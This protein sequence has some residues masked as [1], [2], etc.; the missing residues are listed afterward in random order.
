VIKK[1][2]VLIIEDNEDDA[3]LIVNS[4]KEADYDPEFLI[5]DTIQELIKSLQTR[6]WDC[7]LSD[8][9][10]PT[11]NGLQSLIEFQKFNLTI[12]FIIV[13]G[14]IGEEL[15]VKVMKAGA[16]DFVN[17]NNLKFL[18]PIIEDRL[19]IA[20][21]R[22]QQIRDQEALVFSEKQLRESN[23]SKD[24]FFSIISH[25]LRSPINGI[26]GIS[27]IF[28]DEI[29]DLSKEEIIK[30]VDIIHQNCKYINDHL[31]N[32]LEWSRIQTGS[33]KNE[34]TMLNLAENVNKIVLLLNLN[35]VNKKIKL[36]VSLNDNYKV[37]ADQNCLQSILQNLISNSI[38]YTRENG[39]INICSAL[40]DGF[41][42]ISIS[43]NGVGMDENQMGKLFKIDNTYS[44]PGTNEERGTGL[45]LLL[46]KE[47]IELNGGKISI[48]SKY[49]EGTNISFTLPH[50]DS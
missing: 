33:M 22:R 29:N 27:Q 48:R 46:C 25:D 41:I 13:S 10:L 3:V 49:G 36:N 9:S 17:K 28:L 20:E 32:L 35:A 50:I 47:L 34:P 4:L 1:I 43:D 12:P 37:Y 42:E 23:A 38:K 30:Y 18:V 11:F 2:R 6:T 44:T 7:V 16:S 5:V 40:K 45:G 26:L 8:Y 21:N 39:E 19:L 15:A 31:S 14:A 24:K